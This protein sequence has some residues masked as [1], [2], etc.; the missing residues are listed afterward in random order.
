MSEAF[1]PYHRWLGIAPKDQPPHHYRLLGIDLFEDDTE[2]IRDAAERQTVHVRNYQLGRHSALSQKIL[3]ELA[4]A[5]TCLLDRIKKTAYD[6]ELIAKLDTNKLSTGQL[7]SELAPSHPPA[8]P[9]PPA[10]SLPFP[11]FTKERLSPIVIEGG[12]AASTDYF[13]KKDLWPHNKNRSLYIGLGTAVILT[14]IL[15]AL[16]ALQEKQKESGIQK[17]VA[18]IE[19]PTPTAEQNPPVSVAKSETPEKDEPIGQTAK[20]DSSNMPPM[21]DH[22]IPVDN[23]GIAQRDRDKDS[24]DNIFEEPKPDNIEEANTNMPQAQSETHRPIQRAPLSVESEKPEL[25]K[26]TSNPSRSRSSARGP[27]KKN[28]PHFISGPDNRFKDIIDRFFSAF[29]NNNTKEMCRNFGPEMI[30]SLSSKKD[31]KDFGI[32]CSNLKKQHGIITTYDP[33]KISRVNLVGLP[34]VTQ[35]MVGN[36]IKVTTTTPGHNN[37]NQ[38][39]LT[40]HCEKGETMEL[41]IVIDYKGEYIIGLDFDGRIIG[42]KW[43]IK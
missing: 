23:N 31:L 39:S 29:N 28:K 12:R 6:A 4:A 16:F 20:A 5:K 14:V 30:N 24:N 9:P 36:Q 22:A 43:K 13:G 8:P 25:E 18:L 42:P 33:P 1:D 41:I 15:L 11:L 2:V 19:K 7:E 34:I 10:S 21:A 40:A 3:N 32:F 27:D 17:S 37:A 38:V 26:I 35:T